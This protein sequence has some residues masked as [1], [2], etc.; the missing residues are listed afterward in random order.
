M[1][2]TL[3]KASFDDHMNTLFTIID[4]SAG[5]VELELV[6][7]EENITEK[8]Y[9]FSILF[10]GPADMPLIQKI[11]KIE[12]DRMGTLD[13]FLVP[14]G[15]TGAGLEYEAVFSRFSELPA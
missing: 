10:V 11:Y 5:P 9:S 8:L 15:Q 4:E 14:V 1:L 3:T 2:E 12:H 7:A 6:E 13:L